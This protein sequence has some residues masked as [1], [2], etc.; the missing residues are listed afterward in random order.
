M[1]GSL[2]F[3]VGYGVRGAY[4]FLGMG[5]SVMCC[6]DQGT[7]CGALRGKKRC[8]GCKFYKT[9]EQFLFEA[10]RAEKLL[11]AKGLEVYRTPEN[12]VGARN[13]SE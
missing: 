9:A 3:G 8:K 2:F 10:N 4:K 12:T 1:L 7:E 11:K 6:F 13:R 5:E